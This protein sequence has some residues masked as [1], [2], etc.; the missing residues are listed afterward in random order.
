MDCVDCPAG[1]GS[2]P[3]C[4]SFFTTNVTIACKAC[5]KGVSYS[6]SHDHTSCKSCR[7]CV[8]NEEVIK[9]CTPTSDAQCGEC[10]PG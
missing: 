10:K 9:E 1:M 4:G 3:Q 8:E 2:F 5:V 7:M 6:E